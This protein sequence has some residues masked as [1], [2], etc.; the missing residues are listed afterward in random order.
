[1][2]DTGASTRDRRVRITSGKGNLKGPL[3]NTISAIVLREADTGGGV[4][5]GKRTSRLL[6][7]HNVK[8]EPCGRMAGRSASSI[9]LTQ[10]R[11]RTRRWFGNSL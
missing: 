4:V 3:T 9:G 10:P 1:M 11:V 8:L 2:G 7:L 5:L 6:D